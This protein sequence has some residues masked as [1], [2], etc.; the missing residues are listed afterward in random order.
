MKSIAQKIELE[1]VC[2]VLLQLVNG[3]VHPIAKH[4]HE[5]IWYP[6]RSKTLL[7][8]V[9]YVPYVQSIVTEN[10]W[11]IACYD[12]E[13]VRVWED[14]KWRPPNWQTYGADYSHTMFS[15][16]GIH[17]SIPSTPLDGGKQIRKLI[18][19]LEEGRK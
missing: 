5:L 19:E 14:N 11:I 3:P 2:Y 8:C 4:M 13:D 17:Q 10:P 9:Q 1:G 12:R 15:I 6:E 18:E 16:L 7:Q